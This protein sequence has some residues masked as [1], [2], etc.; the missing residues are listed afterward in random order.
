MT[1][2]SING[3]IASRANCDK[4]YDVICFITFQLIV[5]TNCVS[6]QIFGHNPRINCERMCSNI[7][8]SNQRQLVWGRF[9]RL[10]FVLLFCV[11]EMFSLLGGGGAK[12]D[13]IFEILYVDVYISLSLRAPAFASS[14]SRAT[15]R[16]PVV[17]AMY[18]AV[19][20]RPLTSSMCPKSCTS[21]Y[22]Q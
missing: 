18:K 5:V 14:R 6:S 9:V 11:L 19:E 8:I 4:P 17:A 15:S 21:Q 10:M 7:L 1:Y 13:V 2:L 3:W 12:P 22:K 16:L 20:P